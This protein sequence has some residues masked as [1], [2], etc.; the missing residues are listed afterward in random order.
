MFKEIPAS[1]SSILRRKTIYSVGVNDAG[2]IVSPMINGKRH[3]C[4]F[5]IRWYAMIR[6][7][8]SAKNLE[9][10]PTY[11]GC[12]V[13]N[14]WLVF[15]NFKAWMIT[16]DWKEKQLDKDILITGNKIYSSGTCIFVPDFINTILN[17]SRA[18]RGA[19]PIGVDFDKRRCKFR[20]R[21][22]I[23]GKEVLIGYYTAAQAAKEAYIKAK[24]KN[25]IN[26]AYSVD[27]IVIKDALIR[28]A[29]ELR[30]KSNN[31]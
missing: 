7:C 6:R 24:C 19:L 27:N 10:Y 5:Y 14:E 11:N 16:Q 21:V 1:K 22:N 15:S 29:G 23:S 31:E 26:V 20:S 4:P 8:Y 9:S 2:Y 12:S 13:S 17:D 18:N 30:V 25:I 3:R 28:I